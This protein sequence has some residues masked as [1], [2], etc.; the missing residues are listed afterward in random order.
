[1]KELIK[2]IARGIGL[3]NFVDAKAHQY[4]VNKAIKNKPLEERFSNIYDKKVWG[5]NQESLSGSGS[6]L[7]VT[8]NVREWLPGVLKELNSNC[9]IDLGCGD[10]NWMKEIELPCNY[11]GLDIV[12]SV[13]DSNNSSYQT[14]KIKFLHFNALVDKLPQGDVVLCRD[15]LFHLSFEDGKKLI[16][17][18]KK[19]DAKYFIT[20][21]HEGVDENTDI[22]SGNFRKISLVIP[23]YNFPEPEQKLYEESEMAQGRYLGVWKISILK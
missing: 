19:S 9:L 12:Q 18:V 22:Y 11:L 5:A 15:V 10:F 23:P 13:I 17:N 20:T 8:K 14:E 7:E 21:S 3:G 2:K 1:M 6:T 16:D 4:K